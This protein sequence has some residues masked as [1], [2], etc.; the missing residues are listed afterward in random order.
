[1]LL[2]RFCSLHALLLLV[3]ALSTVVPILAH[4]C[5]FSPPQRGGYV[6]D[7]SGE[8]TCYREHEAGPCGNIPAGDSVAT[9][10]AGSH[11]EVAFQQVRALCITRD[12]RRLH[13]LCV[14]IVTNSE[15]VCAVAPRCHCS[16]F[17]M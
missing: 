8:R 2:S 15:L 7:H 4:V 10:T 3:V 16:P 12:N 17:R 9:F 11:I 6:L 14:L 1:M 13:A 5:L